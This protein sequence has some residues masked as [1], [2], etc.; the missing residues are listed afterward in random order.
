MQSLSLRPSCAP[1]ASSAS[2]KVQ[3]ADACSNDHERFTQLVLPYLSDAYTLARRLI[4]DP[5][6]SEDV[7]QDACLRAYRGIAGFSNGNARAWVMTIVRHTAYSWLQ[8]NRNGAHVLVDDL[9][10]VES[11]QINGRP[12]DSPETALDE[13][14]RAQRLQAAIEALP[15]SFRETLLLHDVKNFT[16]RQIAVL[17]GVS[18]GTVMS[19]FARARGRL[20]ADMRS[21]GYGD[22]GD[23]AT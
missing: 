2:R 5:I 20:I 8:K 6:D 12:V 10:T 22:G 9:E 1:K 15:T 17:T 13:K 16:Y 3:A 18:I 7:V 14:D 23:S 21:V 4:R 19:R 11:Q